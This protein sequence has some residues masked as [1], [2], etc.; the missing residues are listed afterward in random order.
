VLAATKLDAI[1]PRDIRDLGYPRFGGSAPW[2]RDRRHRRD[3]LRHGARTGGL[4]I[5]SFVLQSLDPPRALC[6]LSWHRRAT[7]S[8]KRAHISSSMCWPK[9]TNALLHTLPDRESIA[10]ATFQ[11]GVGPE[12]IPI[13]P[14][15]AVQTERRSRCRQVTLSSLSAK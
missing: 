2:V 4:I 8:S 13:L 10:F 6:S 11:F 9:V 5:H 7:P 14:C 12:G 15:V 1:R 3:E